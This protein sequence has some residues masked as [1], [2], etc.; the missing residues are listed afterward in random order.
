MIELKTWLFF[1]LFSRQ[2]SSPLRANNKLFH[3]NEEAISMYTV[4]KWNELE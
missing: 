2:T 1:S 3:Q 4:D